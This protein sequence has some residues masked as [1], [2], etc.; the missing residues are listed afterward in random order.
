MAAVMTLVL[1]ALALALLPPGTAAA[2]PGDILVVDPGPPGGPQ[3]VRVDPATGARTLVSANGAPAGGPDMRRPLGIAVA[4]GGDILVADSQAF[5]GGGVIRIDPAT[6]ARTAV[7]ANGAPAGGPDFASPPGLAL[8]SDG[9]I[10]ATD[11]G[12]FKGGVGGVIRV[13]PDLGERTV[14]SGPGMPS[15]APNFVS[16]FGIAVE[17]DGD[18]V[19]VDQAAFNPEAGII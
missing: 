19:V 17:A 15:G 14:V 16:P 12:G 5:A 3:V 18:L 1:A 6:G 10:V 9:Y 8:E 13:D 11:S 7:S 2:A 4:P